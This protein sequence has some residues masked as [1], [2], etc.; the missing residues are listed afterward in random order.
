MTKVDVMMRC[1]RWYAAYPLG[2]RH[3]EKMMKE[4]GVV[5]D[6]AKVHRWAVKIL[7]VLAKK[8]SFAPA[9]RRS[10]LADG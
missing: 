4:R 8:N 2:F 1:V 5:V 10:K 7:P 6:H 9:S 3:I